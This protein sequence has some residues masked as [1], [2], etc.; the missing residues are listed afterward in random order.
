M[1]AEYAT[2][3]MPIAS[4]SDLQYFVVLTYCEDGW[5]LSIPL[6]L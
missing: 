1:N 5:M 2:R 6:A 4:L 3:A